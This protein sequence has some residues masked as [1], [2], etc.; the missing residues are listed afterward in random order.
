VNIVSTLRRHLCFQEKYLVW[1]IGFSVGI[2]RFSLPG[3]HVEICKQSKEQ[4][5][6][7]PRGATQLV[8]KFLTMYETPEGSLTCSQIEPAT[9][10]YP[11]PD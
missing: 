10:P 9:G 5:L 3:R 8:K 6:G 7:E 4:N 1:L 11:E 2:L